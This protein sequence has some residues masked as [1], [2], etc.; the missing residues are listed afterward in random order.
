MSV[1]ILEYGLLM[2]VKDW[3]YVREIH[4]SFSQTAVRLPVPATAEVIKND[5]YPIIEQVLAAHRPVLVD[6]RPHGHSRTAGRVGQQPHAAAGSQHGLPAADARVV[7]GHA[8]NAP[9]L[10]QRSGPVHCHLWPLRRPEGRNR[11]NSPT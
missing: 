1:T 5:W 11:P 8:K 10:N 3:G 6:Y 7:A 4:G 2:P 9:W